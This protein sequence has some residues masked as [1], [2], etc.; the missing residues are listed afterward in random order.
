[1]VTH[2]RV[3]PEENKALV[4]ILTLTL[5]QDFDP[6]PK[7]WSLILI[8]TLTLTLTMTPH[9]TI[10]LALTQHNPCCFVYDLSL[11][12]PSSGK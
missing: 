8:L 4:V 10:L 6:K 7:P 11:V 9:Q 2:S 3:G 5:S 12:L 1:M